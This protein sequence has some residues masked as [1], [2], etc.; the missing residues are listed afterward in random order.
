MSRQNE[1]DAYLALGV[2]AMV[3]MLLYLVNGAIREVK[4]PRSG[5]IQEI[6]A[7]PE[8]EEVEHE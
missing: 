3:L 4:S 6:A 7:E 8:V 1:A 5:V 2:L